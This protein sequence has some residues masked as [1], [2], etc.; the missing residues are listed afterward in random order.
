VFGNM[1]LGAK[2]SSAFVLLVLLSMIVGG[3]GY[4]GMNKLSNIADD[5]GKNRMVKVDALGTLGEAQTAIKSAERTLMISGLDRSLATRQLD[6]IKKKWDVADRAWKKYESLPITGAGKALWD[7]QVASWNAWKKDHQE[8]MRLYGEYARSNYN[9]ALQA[10]MQSQGM[11]K[12]YRS[13]V[14]AENNLNAVIEYNNKQ[15]DAQLMA[16]DSAEKTALYILFGVLVLVLLFAAVMGIMFVKNIN[17]IVSDLL[18]ETERLVSAAIAGKLDTR[19]NVKKVN[20]EFRGI[21]EGI[22]KTL[23][24]VIG[25]LNV[26]AE[27]VDRISKGDIPPKITDSYNGDFNEIKNNLNQAIDAVNALVTDATMLS[28]AA[29]DGKLDTRA[30]ASKHGGDFRKIV[31][32]VNKTLDSVIGPLNVAAEYVDRISKGD[33]PPK[34]T[35]SY[36]GDFNE[37]KNN[38]NQAIDAVNALVTDAAML[39]QAAVQGK[40]DTRADASKHGGD[41]RKIVEGVNKTLDSVIGPLNVAAEYVDRISKGDIPPK[42]TDNYNGDFN[43]IKNNLNQ[44]IDAV[45]ALVADAGMLVTAAVEGKLATRADA[46]KHQGDYRKIVEGVNKTLDSVIGP[47]N[48]AADYVDKISRGNMPPVITDNYNGDFNTI[49]NNLN[50]CIEAVNGLIAESVTLSRAAVEGRLQTRGKADKFEGGYREIVQGVNDTLDAVLKPIEE[51]ASCLKEMANGNLNVEVKGNYQG[52][53]AIIKDALNGTIDAMND[54]LGQVSMAVEQV[55]AGSREI[56]TSSQALSQGATESAS[57][58]EEISA[59]MQEMGSQTNQNAENATQANKL[60]VLARDNAERGNGQ[61]TQMVKA[62]GDINQSA[63]N[64]S[65]I[66]KVI[67]EIAFQTNLLALN[68]AVEAARAGKHGKGFTVVAEEVRNL[69]QRSAKAAKETTEMI[70][71]SI[72]RTEVGTAIAENTSKALEE[73]VVGATKVTD[74]ISEI[75]AASKEQAQGIGQINNGLGQVDQVTQQ[76]TASAEEMA[77]AG[78]ELSSQSLQLKQMLAKFQ[79]KKA[80]GSHLGGGYG[81]GYSADHYDAAPSMR[82]TAGRQRSDVPWGGTPAK[83]GRKNARGGEVKPEE[84]ISLD[85]QHFGKF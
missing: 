3:V 23:D 5:L 18:S 79:L 75:A 20:F 24:A 19:G 30:D 66:I 68:A 85:D 54:I 83:S 74:L 67:D 55:S 40:L 12:G 21:V 14:E 22:N 34:I 25:P 64:I 2:V 13:F 84:I 48:V 78:E 4:W 53:H 71:D 70:E 32:G 58:V 10:A 49:K 9:P 11:D 6:E 17:G 8:F 39:S 59:S 38:L 29:V 37:I 26:A 15:A 28:Q 33:I 1:K 61:M 31:E 82:Q 72:K 7:K 56:A 77:S 46:T 41:F 42:I 81:S 16:A 80:A 44:A 51:A 50:R 76:N 62:M 57:A 27:Y 60:A 63:N 69:A 36:S 35:D 45:N 47:L 43:E 65:K 52:D 73:I